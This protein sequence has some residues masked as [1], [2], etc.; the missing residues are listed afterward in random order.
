M[1]KSTRRKFLTATAGSALLPAAAQP[2]DDPQDP[3]IH[4]ALML[5]LLTE[6][7]REQFFQDPPKPTYLHDTIM[8]KYP[9]AYKAIRDQYE[10]N[11]GPG[12][13]YS[14][15]GA[16]KVLTG[17]GELFFALAPKGAYG[18]GNA[19]PCSYNDQPCRV[20]SLLLNL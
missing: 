14:V 12:L 16:E 6:K 11:V 7:Y 1:T 13:K 5:L 9:K 4:T 10:S 3:A 17:T 20:I 2:T 15:S 8:K 19:C 18:S